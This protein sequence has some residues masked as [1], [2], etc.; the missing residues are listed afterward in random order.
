MPEE[1]LAIGFDRSRVVMMNEAHDAL[2]RCV[3][4]REVGRRVL[5]AAHAAGVRHLA[6]EALPQGIDAQS[7]WSYALAQFESGY[8]AQPEMRQLIETSG[9]ARL[10]AASVRDS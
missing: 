4:T 8:V 7:D 5:P 10:D 1:L 9:G 3:R 2:K 6:M